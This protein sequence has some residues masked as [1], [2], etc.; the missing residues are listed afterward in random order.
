MDAMASLY[1]RIVTSP[2]SVFIRPLTRARWHVIWTEPRAEDRA[3]RDIK[4]LGFEC[5]CPLERYRRWKRNRRHNLTRPLFPR[6]AFVAFDS[7]QPD[8][9]QICHADGVFDVLRNDGRPMR[10]PDGF[11]ESLK[12]AEGLGLFDHT[13][14]PSPFAIGS[15]VQLDGTGPFAKMIGMVKRARARDRIDV[16]L[17]YLNR[18]VIVNVL[19]MRLSA[20]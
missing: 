18:E 15:Q 19:I 9:G 7:R 14:T 10:L 8:W 13:K 2:P 16:L 12:H 5:Y 6:Y 17:K 3:I 20:A 1:D 4:Q 11:V